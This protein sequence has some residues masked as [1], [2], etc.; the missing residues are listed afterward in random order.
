MR[1]LNRQHITVLAALFVFSSSGLL[2]GCQPAALPAAQRPAVKLPIL[3]GNHT[4]GKQVY[5]RE[6][7]TC[8]Q[9]GAG[10]NSK[11]PQL[12]R[13]YGATAATLAD[14]QGR[15]SSAIQKSGWTWDTATLDRYIAEPAQALP[16]GKMLSDPLPDR[17]E[18]QAVIAYLSTLR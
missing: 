5:E 14:Y 16:N 8:H 13:I 6:C 17:V 7:G 1:M 10:R 3:A 18:R 9:L 15:Y 2:L 4:L 12:E 11:A